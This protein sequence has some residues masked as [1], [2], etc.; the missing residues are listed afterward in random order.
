VRI[1]IEH[2]IPL[3]NLEFKL[4]MKPLVINTTI[5]QMVVL[6]IEISGDDVLMGMLLGTMVI[7][8]DPTLF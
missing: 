5:G 4:L 1:I 2:D 7:N 8:S 6:T 3:I